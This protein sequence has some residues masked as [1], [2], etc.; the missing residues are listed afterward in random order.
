LIDTT[1]ASSRISPRNT[2][3]RGTVESYATVPP[4]VRN[5]ASAETTVKQRAVEFDIDPA[6]I[7]I[8]T[9][10]GLMCIVPPSKLYCN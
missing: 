7:S 5:A 8:H 6:L 2:T 3:A 1:R 10:F 9:D 4:R